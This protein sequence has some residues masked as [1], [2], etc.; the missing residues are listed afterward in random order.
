MSSRLQDAQ[1]AA[2]S[3][4]FLLP[5]GFEFH[6]NLAGWDNSERGYDSGFFDGMVSDVEDAYCVDRDEVFAA[7]FSRRRRLR[8]AP[9]MRSRRHRRAVAVNSAGDDLKDHSGF[10]SYRAL[11][12]PGRIHPAVRFEQA[13]DGDSAYAVPEFATTSQLYQFLNQ[14]SGASKPA[15][16]SNPVRTSRAADG[17]AKEYVECSFSTQIGHALPLSWAQDT[18]DFFCQ[19]PQNRPGCEPLSDNRESNYGRRDSTLIC[20]SLGSVL[21]RSMPRIPATAFEL[22]RVANVSLSCCNQISLASSRDDSP[23]AAHANGVDGGIWIAASC[24][25][26]LDWHSAS[27]AGHSLRFWRRAVLVSGPLYRRR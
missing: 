12:C 24:K 15:P 14:L 27:R 6:D 13:V 21:E 2:V 3:A 7:G 23:P 10:R 26:D 1:A 19:L 22:S 11:P 5:Q 17:C 20:R 18:W 25:G 4:V 8:Q 9:R 16:S